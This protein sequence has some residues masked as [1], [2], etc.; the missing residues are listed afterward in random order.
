M[1]Q[2]ASMKISGVELINL[3]TYWMENLKGVNF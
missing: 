2:M 3:G 1:E